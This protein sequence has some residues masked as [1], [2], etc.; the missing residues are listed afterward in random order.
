MF[1]YMLPSIAERIK[2]KIKATEVKETYL[3]KFE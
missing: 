2:V 3:N 1:T